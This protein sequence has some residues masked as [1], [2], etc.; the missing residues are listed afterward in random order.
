MAALTAYLT[1]TNV[2]TDAR[3]L[4]ASPPAAETYVVSTLQMPQNGTGWVELHARAEAASAGSYQGSE[5]APS[6]HGFLYNVTDLEAQKILSGTWT[7]AIKLATGGASNTVTLVLH[8]RAFIR[9]SNG[10][11]DQI[12]SDIN[13]N[14]RQLSGATATALTFAGTALGESAEFAAGDKLY[15]DLIAEVTTGFSS[16][17]AT[18]RV[19]RLYENGG[20]ADAVVTPGY[21]PA[22]PPKSTEV[23]EVGLELVDIPGT[24]TNHKIRIRGRLQGGTGVFKAALYEGTTDRSGELTSSAVSLTLAT[25]DLAV[26]D[27]AAAAITD[28]NNLSVKFWAYSANGNGTVAEIADIW[29]EMPLPAEEP[30]ANPTAFLAFL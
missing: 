10:T 7:P 24:R 17:T 6:G 2:L 15:I 4:V 30:P 8:V 28:Y 25:Y 19:F 16:S 23:G 1:T 20:A 9:H 5:P 3:E 12:G 26:S 18:R 29:L 21:Q 11:Y 14:S 22:N 27:A 13:S